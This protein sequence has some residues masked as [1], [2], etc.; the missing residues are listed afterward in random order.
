LIAL[1]AARAIDLS[2]YTRRSASFGAAVL[3]EVSVDSGRS[4]G[5]S[6][7]L[8]AS[9]STAYVPSTVSLD[10]LVGSPCSVQ[11]RWRVKPDSTGTTGTFRMDDVTMT[12][13][14][15]IDA[16]LVSVRV[17]AGTQP[18]A[19]V[20]QTS[21]V[22]SGRRP[23]ETFSVEGYADRDL[24]GSPGENERFG[25]AIGGPLARGETSVQQLDWRPA[26][27]ET[28]RLILIVRC[29]EDGD[30]RNDRRDTTLVSGAPH[31]SVAVNE[32]MYAPSGDEP[33]WVELVNTGSVPVALS[34]WSVS[35]AG[36]GS[37]HPFSRSCLLA[38]EGGCAV[39]CKDSAALA[40]V[41]PVAAGAIIPVPGFPSLNNS[42]DAV[43]LFDERGEVVDSVAYLPAWAS[44]PGASLERVDA[45]TAAAG[46]DN[47]GS[48]TDPSGATPGQ[49]NSIR[50]LDQDL[51]AGLPAVTRDAGGGR[52]TIDLI[53]RNPGRT[54]PGAFQVQ[55]IDRREGADPVILTTLEGPAGILPGD[56]AGLRWDWPDPAPG[57]HLV[58]GR[59]VWGPDERAANDSASAAVWIPFTRG[60][61]V[62]SEIMASPLPGDAE[63]VE[64]ANVSGAGVDLGDWRLNGRPLAAPGVE[65]NLSAGAFAVMASDS[66][67]FRRFPWLATAG[68]HVAVTHVLLGLNNDA[69]TVVLRDPEGRTADSVRYED[70]WH[71]PLVVDHTGRALEKIRMAAAGTD[72]KNWSTCL[73]SSGGTP[74]APNSLQVRETPGGGRLSASPNPFSP[75]ADGHDDFT[76][77]RFEVPQGVVAVNVTIFDVRGRLTRHLAAGQPVAASG[78]ALWDGLDDRGRSVAVGQYV[79]LLE[80]SDGRAGGGFGAKCVVVVARQL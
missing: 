68:V 38:P 67:I 52:V 36:V 43:V 45:L 27:A 57:A 4:F 69:D 7:P 24:D 14:P 66:G 63:Y 29:A 60:P 70:G 5:P 16:A 12:S 9:G 59:I 19:W 50:R 49:P 42:G 25:V 53:V 56:S 58:E 6:V 33:E 26:T 79:V 10:S 28:V 65:A 8:T 32:I 61:I 2:F 21:V 71:S 51:S 80:G 35:D 75:D 77:I 31:R 20:I 41:R 3:L 22:N 48:S 11:L 74:G 76:L 18:T 39:L 44:R 46:P 55:L 40:E 72:R 13:R 34:G 54:S 1:P 17:L 15:F 47:W 62:V 37:K 30:P 64:V 78:E 73:A 23:I